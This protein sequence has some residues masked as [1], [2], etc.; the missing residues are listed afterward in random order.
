L[1]TRR[2][3]MLDLIDAMV[4][5]SSVLIN[6]AAFTYYLAE[7]V[8]RRL[9]FAGLTGAWVGLAMGLGAAGRLAFS[10]QQP[11]PLIGVLLAVPLLTVGLLAFR[12][13]RA[14][15]ALLGIPTPVLIAL[16]SAR[17]FGVMFLVL[18]AAG[19]LSGPF[20]YFAGLGD[21]ITGAIAIPLALRVARSPQLPV[22]AVRVWNLFGALDLLVAVGLG[23][24]SANGSPMQLF[25]A[26][27][28]SDAVQQL[29]ACLIPTV[30]V[31]FYLITH[32][33]VAA[34]LAEGRAVPALAHG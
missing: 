18:A 30:L 20:P 3:V 34:K 2:F 12:S 21:M 19:R 5:M 8:A 28:G 24:M 7:T 6:L 9:V 11:I 22:G 23:I 25:H 29:P 1:E 16:N 13:P 26:G 14:R 32:G 17:I 10:P 27:V 31:P 4:L 33:I 15:A